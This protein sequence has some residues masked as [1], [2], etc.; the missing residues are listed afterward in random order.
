MALLT[1][2]IQL[3]NTQN[4]AADVMRVRAQLAEEEQK[5]KAEQRL[6]QA[7]IE[8]N[9]QG[10]LQAQRRRFEIDQRLQFDRERTAA[11]DDRQDR[12]LAMEEEMF[13]EDRRPAGYSLGGDAGQGA[14]AFPIVP[15]PSAP[16]SGGSAPAPRAPRAPRSGG[17]SSLVPELPLSDDAGALLAADAPAAPAVDAGWMGNTFGGVASFAGSLPSLDAPQP[18]PVRQPD[19]TMSAAPA[20]RSLAPPA[21]SSDDS[22]P[23]MS[24]APQAPAMQTP[25][26]R[27]REMSD[28]LISLNTRGQPA[29]ITQK[30]HREI[31]RAAAPKILAQAGVGGATA[32]S[33]KTK[34]PINEMGYRVNPEN[35]AQ[36]FEEKNGRFY[37]VRE[38]DPQFGMKPLGDGLYQDKNGGKFYVDSMSGRGP[39]M[40]RFVEDQKASW[41]VNERNNVYNPA[42]G[43]EFETRTNYRG[44]TYKQVHPTDP[45]YGMVPVGDGLYED[46]NGGRFFVETRGPKGPVMKRVEQDEKVFSRATDD[47]GRIHQYNQFGQEVGVTSAEVSFL[48]P[49][50]KPLFGSDGKVHAWDTRTG[51]FVHGQPEG[52]TFGTGSDIYALK[53]GNDGEA[54][55]FDKKGQ[56][57]KEIPAGVRFDNKKDDEVSEWRYDDTKKELHGFNWKGEKIAA[58]EG[59]YAK[60]AASAN[61]YKE[62]SMSE[63]AM[64]EAMAPAVHQLWAVQDEI[65][66]NNA[67]PN[68]SA[69]ALRLQMGN[70]GVS[71]AQRRAYAAKVVDELKIKGKR[72]GSNYAEGYVRS[73]EAKAA[74]TP[75]APPAAP[76]GSTGAPP[77]PAAAAK[78]ATTPPASPTPGYVKPK[79]AAWLKGDD[80]NLYEFD[81]DTKQRTGKVQ[82]Q[83]AK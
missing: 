26:Q 23:L 63:R 64:Y 62:A 7:Q 35:S 60:L 9:I 52:V 4:F 69:D 24:P 44:T 65:R 74:A 55:P 67:D 54:Y 6:A 37:Q 31:L 32:E 47:Q 49:S 34:W 80:G 20:Q 12:R 40:K 22:M 48:K 51:E 56:P 30:A 72:Q 27:I 75:P 79:K 43:Q 53:V 42:T 46:A 70:V 8:Q 71:L 78:P 11:D 59:Q 76:T 29:V 13:L 3:P 36:M 28:A 15:T 18:A 25:A 16:V 77:A 41:P 82:V 10:A 83:A 17:G 81:A 61:F 66:K 38:T 33:P 58:N 2:P 21:P 68:A 14:G 19:G 1:T 45:N 39:V 5:K 73:F 57:M 50:M